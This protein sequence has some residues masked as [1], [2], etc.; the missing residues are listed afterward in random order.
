M[1]TLH[2]EYHIFFN[3]GMERNDPD[4]A[5][6]ILNHL[7]LKEGLEIWGKKGRDAIHSDMKQLHIRDTFLLVKW[8]NIWHYQKKQTMESHMFLK[9]KRH[10]TIKRR[11]LSGGNKQRY[12]ISK[13]DASLPNVST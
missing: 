1:G 13:E 6:A 4:I 11:I 9:Y 2:L 3:Q 12:F 7:S 10:A 8:K 5:G